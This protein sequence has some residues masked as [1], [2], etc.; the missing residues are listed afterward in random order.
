MK[1]V[2]FY[3]GLVAVAACVTPKR[4]TDPVHH[5]SGRSQ[6][7]MVL[8][9]VEARHIPD[10]DVRLTRQLNIS[11][12]ILQHYGKDGAVLA[13]H[14]ATETLSLV[15]G[16]LTGHALLA[17]WV[18]V[19]QLARKA[20]DGALATEA[21]RRALLELERMPSPADRCDY[22]IGVAEELSLTLGAPAAIA[23]LVKTG[24]WAAGIEQRETRRTARLAFASAL[25]ILEDYEG[26]ATIL[27]KEND[28]LWSSDS[29]VQLASPSSYY[30]VARAEAPV[31]APSTEV[32][33]RAAE[34]TSRL[35][36]FSS[37]SV[38]GDLA[39]PAVAPPAYGKQLGFQP[40]FEGRTSST[41]ASSQRN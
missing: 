35:F 12:E 21:A 37:E 14:E 8:A 29:M 17:G 38:E 15:G 11:N 18:S 4:L 25:F 10:A 30:A 6:Q 31:A 26:G 33:V 16:Q 34:P 24:D 5:S 36:N 27:R 19:A 28:P 39:P 7:L 13:L 2:L 9:A 1:K 3:C 32:V 40:V 22:V 41:A 23:L 20:S